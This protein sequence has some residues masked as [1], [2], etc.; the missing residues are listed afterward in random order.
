MGFI[1]VREVLE[2]NGF[3]VTCF[4]TK[5]E[6][7]GYLVNQLKGQAL[8]FGGSM[9]LREIGL[10]DAL[11]P[12]AAGEKVE[13]FL[14]SANAL[15]ETGEIVNIDGTGNRIAAAYYGPQKLIY[16][17]G[18]NKLQPDLT[19]A[20]DRARN[21]AGPL[22]AK[23]LNKDTPCVEDLKCHDCDSRDRICR[24]LAITWWPMKGFKSTEIVLIDE[25]L[26]Y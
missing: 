16:V 24:G 15:A 10:R 19:S 8:G 23:R 9:T 2:K 5:A 14:L 26:G 11:P 4:D 21:V 1:K 18:R 6:A 20:I 13:T 25:D 7:L 17:I 22:N 12:A 3:K